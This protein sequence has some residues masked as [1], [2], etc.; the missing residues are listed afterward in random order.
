MQSKIEDFGPI[1]LPAYTGVRVMMMP[2][3]MEDPTGT[4]PESLAGYRPALERVCALASPKSG[5]GYLTIDEALV[6]A[7][8][9][10]RRPGLHVDGC[11]PYGGDPTPQW[12]RPY[13]SNGM[14]LASSHEG[15]RGYTQDVEGSPGADGDCEHLRSQLGAGFVMSP[16]RL[17]W[18]SPTA[19][20]EALPMPRDTYRQL[21]RVSMP[22]AAPYHRDYTPNPLGIQPT[23]EPGPSRTRQMA[24]RQ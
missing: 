18:C 5:V 2:F 20:H 4:L 14:F 8:E 13:A 24:F 16:G 19:L 21:L 11:G 6:R 15:C 9:T 1:E 10:H 22:S 17:Y 23:G 12:P 3:L 7:G